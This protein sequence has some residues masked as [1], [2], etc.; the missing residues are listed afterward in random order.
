MLELNRIITEIGDN[1]ETTNK[2]TVLHCFVTASPENTRRDIR[3]NIE[4]KMTC[5]KWFT[6]EKQ[7]KKFNLDCLLVWGVFDCD[8]NFIPSKDRKMGGGV[9]TPSCGNG[10]KAWSDSDSNSD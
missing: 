10:D 6:I 1:F 2:L 5:G 8:R 4:I 3:G 9:V 7:L